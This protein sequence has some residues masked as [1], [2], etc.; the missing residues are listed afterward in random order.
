[1]KTRDRDRNLR[2]EI[3]SP[4]MPAEAAALDNCDRVVPYKCPPR[5]RATV[6]SRRRHLRR[7][8]GLRDSDAEFQELTVDAWCT[9]KKIRMSNLADQLSGLE[10]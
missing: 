9:P 4:N 7:Y 8:R 10:G 2:K 6:F 3:A 5:L 1:V